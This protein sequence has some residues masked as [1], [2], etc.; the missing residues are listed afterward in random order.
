MS[1]ITPQHANGRAYRVGRDRS[2]D[3]PI[4]DDSVSRL[5]A[6]LVLA[7]DGLFVTDCNSTNGTFVVRLH[8]VEE[9]VT[10][11][12]AGAGDS[13]KFGSVVVAVRDLMEFIG[14]RKSPP[15]AAPPPPPVP[16]VAASP[17]AKQPSAANQPSAIAWELPHSDRLVR[18]VCGA[19]RSARQACVLCGE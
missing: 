11:A 7:T 10:Q 4:A 5:H 6:Q 14:S 8:G 17:A 13:I 19:V 12:R 18:C 3:I 1:G 2:A 16:A 15:S 9:P